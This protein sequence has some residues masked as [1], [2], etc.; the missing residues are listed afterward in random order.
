MRF[1][2][3]EFLQWG[4]EAMLEAALAHG[5]KNA[6][7]GAYD[8]ATHYR[9]RQK[10]MQWFADELDRAKKGTAAPGVAVA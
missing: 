4:S 8:R 5:K 2:L 7:V 6:I 10:L 9:E 1:S 3:S